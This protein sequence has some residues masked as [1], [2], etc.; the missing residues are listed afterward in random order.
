MS[1]TCKHNIE[2]RSIPSTQ[3]MLN[4]EKRYTSRPT[5]CMVNHSLPYSD[6]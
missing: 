4:L 6:M 3:C 1:I 2:K 5:H